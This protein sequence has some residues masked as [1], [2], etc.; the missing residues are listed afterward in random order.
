MRLAASSN[1]PEHP[2]LK[3]ETWATH[4]KFVRAILVSVRW[5]QPSTSVR[6]DEAEQLT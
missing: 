2:G 3:S 6:D 1:R 4:S 5:P